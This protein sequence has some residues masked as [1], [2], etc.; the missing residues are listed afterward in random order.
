MAEEVEEDIGVDRATMA[1]IETGKK[2]TRG[3]VTTRT[4]M[5]AAASSW[6]RTPTLQ[7]AESP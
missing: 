1:M 5:R 6:R 7:T 4:R 3:A 2:T